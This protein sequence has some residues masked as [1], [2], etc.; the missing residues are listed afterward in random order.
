[1]P[2]TL[3][4]NN[5]YIRA[6][7]LVNSNNS[8]SLRKIG[9]KLYDTDSTRKYSSRSY[10]HGNTIPSEDRHELTTP[11]LCR[12]GVNKAIS[13][14][15]KTTSM[16]ILLLSLTAGS[17]CQTARLESPVVTSVST[18]HPDSYFP[19]PIITKHSR[20]R[21]HHLPTVFHL[22]EDAEIY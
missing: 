19:T 6:L 9:M 4:I 21:R 10:T 3:P 17:I 2:G 8:T 20:E 1:M 22:A 11:L 7:Y 14:H 16:L 18:A 5:S 15:L 12:A 13:T